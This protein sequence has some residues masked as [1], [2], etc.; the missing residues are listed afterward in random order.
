MEVLDAGHAAIAAIVFLAYVVLGLTGLGSAMVAVPGLVHFLPLT[1]AVPLVLLLDMVSTVSLGA[2]NW[3]RVSR[4]ELVRLVPFMA[5]GIA[6][7]VGA[8]TGLA[9]RPLLVLLGVFVIANSAWN[10]RPRAGRGEVSRAWAAPAGVAGGIFS[11][12]FG[13]GGPVYASYLARRL[14]DDAAALRATIVTTILASALLRVG[15]FAS[16]G[17]YHRGL[18]LAWA[19]LLPFCLLGLWVGGTL[20]GRMPPERAR[21][22]LFLVLLV[23]GVTVLGRAA[24]T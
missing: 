4:A 11:A 2:R 16:A 22:A 12:L 3:R 23:A 13:T 5:A 14:V 6:L 19:A 15:A 8:L 24:R 17:L 18:L 7:G 9:Q 1:V 20:H 21:Q 10:L